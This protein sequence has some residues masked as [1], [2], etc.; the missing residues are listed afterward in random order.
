MA[1]R[2]M[3]SICTT[4]YVIMFSITHA[5]SDNMEI[6]DDHKRKAGLRDGLNLGDNFD[7]I[8][9]QDKDMNA[10]TNSIELGA[11]LS[12]GLGLIAGTD[13]A[14]YYEHND[15]KAQMEHQKDGVFLDNVDQ[16]QDSQPLTPVNGA[17]IAVGGGPFPKLILGFTDISSKEISQQN[18]R[19]LRLQG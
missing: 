8:D 16:H 14:D 15:A 12:A 17:L 6:E 4:A 7:S 13:G 19:H 10:H 18:G 5:N 3:F 2:K 9:Q 1:W 11:G